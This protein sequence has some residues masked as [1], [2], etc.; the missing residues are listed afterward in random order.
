M[1]K[2]QMKPKN[3]IYSTF[4][5]RDYKVYK[6]IAEY[7][8]NSTQSFFDNRELLGGSV[9]I[10]LDYTSDN[11]IIKDNAMGMDLNELKK[12]LELG[13]RPKFNEGRNQ[14]GMGLKVAS[15][16]FT[17][18]WVIRTKKLGSKKEYK[19]R[20]TMD[21]LINGRE[22]VIEESTVHKNKHYTVIELCNLKNRK[23]TGKSAKHLRILLT[24]IYKRDLLSNDVNIFINKEQLVASDFQF[25]NIGNGPIKKDIDFTFAFEGQR[26][27]V[28]GTAGIRSKGSTNELD[29]GFS[30]LDNNRVIIPSWRDPY[31]FG[32]GNSYQ[33]QRLVGEFELNNFKVTSDKQNFDWDNGLNIAFKEELKSR[34]SDLIRTAQDLRFRED[35][36]FSKKDIKTIISNI[37][38]ASTAKEVSISNSEDNLSE[39]KPDICDVFKPVKRIIGNS[40]YFVQVETVSTNDFPFIEY[41]INERTNIINII[42]NKRHEFLKPK[43][44]SQEEFVNYINM[45]ISFVVSLEHT[46]KLFGNKKLDDQYIVGVN[47][48][49]NQFN[50]V[51]Q[52]LGE[53]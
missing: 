16:W 20:I 9:D 17:D 31:I 12:A 24:T 39:K 36:G 45:I 21:D 49:I 51:L 47:T 4:K 27:Q 22:M 3:S 35:E 40:T 29:G 25:A 13:D 1:E 42:C 30:L 53:E 43:L 33:Y 41:S 8:D 5:Y 26:Y 32:A 28:K 19:I 6:A 7:I 10:N 11:I 46:K 38:P 44:N 52:S 50:K 18:E 34:V 2:I 37:K 48:L 15:I 14:F 23:I